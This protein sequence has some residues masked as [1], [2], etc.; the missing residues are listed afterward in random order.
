MYGKS[1]WRSIS[2]NVVT[3]RLPSQVA[4]HAQKFFNRLK[5]A[6]KERKRSS[7]HDITSE[8][9]TDIE[10]P[11]FNNTAAAAVESPYVPTEQPI[12]VDC[13]ETDALIPALPAPLPYTH[14]SFRPSDPFQM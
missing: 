13:F 12:K 7:I 11:Y 2:R 3:T 10:L 6:K 14:Q 9:F 5:S 4:S 1:D 8:S